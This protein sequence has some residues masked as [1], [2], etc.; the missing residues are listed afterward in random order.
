MDAMPRQKRRIGLD[1]GVG[2][3]LMRGFCVTLQ[4]E[5]LDIAQLQNTK[6]VIFGTRFWSLRFSTLRQISGTLRSSNDSTC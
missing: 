2:K 3:A 5:L 4:R 6:E 1:N